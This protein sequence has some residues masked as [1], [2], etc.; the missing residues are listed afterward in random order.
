MKRLIIRFL[1]AGVGLLLL[2]GLIRL[3]LVD[4]VPAH[5]FFA[6]DE[7]LL[8]IAHQ[9]G[10]L[11]RPDNTMLAF[12][13]AV[14]LGV[15]VLEMDIHS[16]KDGVLVVIH[17]DTVDRTTDGNGRVSD[18]TLAE[19]KQLDAAYHWPLDDETQAPYRGQGVTIPTLE[20][21]FTTYPDMR[22]NIEIKQVD[23]PIAEPFCAL[24]RQYG[25]EEQVLV[26]SFRQEAMLAFRDA[27]PEVA[28]SMVEA[29][30]RPF[31][32]LNLVW[33]S[34]LFQ[35]PAEAFQVPERFGLPVV[36]ETQVITPRF[37]RAA[38]RHNIDVHVWTVN[39]QEQMERMI[40]AGVDGI[41]TDR[42]DLLLTVLGRE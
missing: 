18:L 34:G 3:W 32:A 7:E 21:L 26:A 37:V 12:D 10:N 5:P 29:E 27:C 25:M 9:G 31:F 41:I 4:P 20:E 39:E 8:V 14:A 22:M 2:A 17:D 11:I 38:Q 40:A 19:L 1:G 6:A 24:I 13:H 33:L 42:P 15:D 36:G 30:I 28:T 16:T 35:S 23:P